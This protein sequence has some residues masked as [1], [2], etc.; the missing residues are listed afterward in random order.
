MKSRISKKMNIATAI[1][2]IAVV[3]VGCGS[4][5]SDK[6]NVTE[7]SA[8]SDTTT[9]SEQGQTQNI[10]GDSGKHKSSNGNEG[11]NEYNNGSN[12]ETV[13]IAV[14]VNENKYFY[15]NAPIEFDE[16]ISMVQNTEG[17][18]VVSISDNNAALN[19]YNKLTNKLTELG[20]AYEE[21]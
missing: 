17:N 21:K 10:D 8:V 5:S 13:I 11:G 9:S 1:L 20:I 12:Q 14:L 7:V 15:N 6:N 16:M 4:K 19:A 18:V 2:C 3:I